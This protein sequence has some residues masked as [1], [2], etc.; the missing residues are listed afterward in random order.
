[1]IT[2]DASEFFRYAKSLDMQFSPVVAKAVFVISPVGFALAEQ[3]AQDNHYMQ[4]QQTVD[5]Q[6]AICEHQHLQ[7]KLREHCS[8]ICFPGDPA[9]PDSVFPNN[10][11]ATAAGKL[12]I[13]HMRHAVRQQE[14]NRTDIRRFMTEVIGLN[15]IDLSHQPG[16]C[17]LTGSL[18]IDRARGLGFCG[19]SER[20]DE[21]GALAMHQAFGL[22]A[23]LMFDLNPTEYHTNVVLS[24]L[25][26]RAV[27]IAASGFR[28]PEMAEAI[29][30][31]Y[32]PNVVQLTDKQKGD[33]AGNCIALTNRAVFMSQRAKQ[34]L[35]AGQLNQ[36]QQMGFAVEDV[37]MP[38]LELAG[39]SLRCC[40]AELY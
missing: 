3:S 6:Q 26:S 19:L 27:V 11:F 25:A 12:I 28:E 16:I 21:A 15:E 5:A 31:F 40:V 33:Y 39:G 13:G 14:A 2:R 24:V 36:F 22:R 4:M 34:S 1:M 18:I 29:A 35:N 20:C 17:E 30:A 23:T 10:V 38:M 7:E 37:A 8:V 32:S 9:M